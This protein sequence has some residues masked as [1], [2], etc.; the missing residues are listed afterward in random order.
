[1]GAYL[2]QPILD[3][4]TEDGEA[5]WYSLP[6]GKKAGTYVCTCDCNKRGPAII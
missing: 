2:S 6:H 3:K 1:M 5:C 4:E